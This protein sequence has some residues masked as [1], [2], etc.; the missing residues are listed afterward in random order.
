M[1]WM[2]CTWEGIVL[3]SVRWIKFHIAYKSESCILYKWENS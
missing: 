3:A 1:K 2:P